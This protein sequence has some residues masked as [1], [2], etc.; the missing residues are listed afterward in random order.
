MNK[1]D[2]IFD[3]IKK[4][5]EAAECFLNE[6]GNVIKLQFH[7]DQY[8]QF[9]NL[10]IQTYEDGF[11]YARITVNIRHLP[12]NMF[13]VDTNNFPEAENLLISNGIAYDSGLRVY[14][15]YC[16]YPVYRLEKWVY[17]E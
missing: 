12:L 5:L 6:D 11:P 13:A 1:I 3:K 17:E 7:V 9:K 14:S 15:G 8:A 4:R 10:M 16:E 2:P